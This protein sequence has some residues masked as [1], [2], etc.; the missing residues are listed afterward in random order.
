MHT[1]SLR[2]ST[3][4][5]TTTG[6][7]TSCDPSRLIDRRSAVRHEASRERRSRREA[8][9]STGS[10]H[11][12]CNSEDIELVL[13]EFADQLAAAV[14]GD[15]ERW[16]TMKATRALFGLIAT[17]ALV[18]GAC[19]SD[20]ESTTT[21]TDSESDAAVNSTAVDSVPAEPTLVGES[22]PASEG[23][24]L[25]ETSTPTGDAEAFDPSLPPVLIG[26]HNLEGGAYSIPE[27][28]SGFEAGVQYVNTELGGI[29]G[30]EL[31]VNYCN[32]DVTPESAIN[33][34]NQ[35]VEEDVVAA[36]QGFDLAVDAAL[37]ILSEAGI[38]EI[39][40]SPLGAAIN[41]N[42]GD[43]IVLGSSTQGG[44][45][46]TG[47]LLA[48]D[49]GAKKL[50]F[51]LA[52]VPSM[53]S[54]FESVET[55]AESMGLEVEAYYYAQPTD[56]TTYAA[57]V[58]SGG[59]DAISMFG[60]DADYLAAIPAFRTAGYTALF[61]ANT[62]AQVEALD[63]SLRE[64]VVVATSYY[65][66]DMLNDIPAAAQA[67]I[68]IYERFAA[69]IDS[70]RP[71]PPRTGFYI[72]VMAADILRQ[73]DDPTSAEAVN[74]QAP[75]AHGRTFFTDTGYDC[76]TPSWP[77]TTSCVG[78]TIYSKLTEDGKFEVLPGQPVD[79]SAVRPS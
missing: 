60:V 24:V 58:L 29:N 15:I 31:Q 65:N 52:D 54:V 79:M 12:H 36:V 49:S 73:V 13:Q 61:N 32:V 40:P 1:S 70:D 23:S 25:S 28:R 9:L 47:L 19:G 10:R 2:I 71:T 18:L 33:C 16:G 11:L 69:S 6:Q 75:M 62:F 27:A 67:D 4:R 42:V 34:A 3:L 45:A 39:A 26:F 44:Q 76:A 53:H 43:A 68:D 5:S 38:L 20:E 46:I 22:T 63:P 50:A 64:N 78:V 66:S 57:T 72:A 8:C 56:W 55:T 41:D 37:P 14:V 7:R 77:D 35:F 21:T 59:A 74:K 17:G 48:A 51:L 30:H